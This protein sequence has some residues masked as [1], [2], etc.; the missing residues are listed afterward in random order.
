MDVVLPVVVGFSISFL[1]TLLPGLI[2]MTAAK[3]SLKEG[4]RNAVHFAL[5]AA[6]I[7]FFQAYIAVSFAKFINRRPD[8]V[9]T[10]E[11]VGVMIFMLLTIYFFFLSKK[12]KTNLNPEE[13]KI[14]SKT[15]NYFLGAMFSA[16]NFFPIPYYVFISISFSAYG[17]FYFTNPFVPLFVVGSVLG[18]FLVFYLY[19]VFFKKFEHK[20]DFFL[21]NVHYF[22]GTVTGTIAVITLLRIW[23]N[24]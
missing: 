13:I 10:L 24:H 16:L 20:T 8:V 22:I 14:R 18:S 21:R 17:Y 11:E 3:I 15:R 19:I 7:V 6:T 2:N 1:A 12:K 5:G 23:K 4:R 9:N